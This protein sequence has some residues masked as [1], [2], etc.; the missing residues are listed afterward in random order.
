MAARWAR[1]LLEEGAE[2]IGIVVLDLHARRS[3]IERI[4]RHQIDPG[5]ALTPGDEG[6]VFSLSLGQPLAAQGPVHAALELL[7]LD[8]RPTLDQVSF[9][10]RSP[11]LAASQ[12]ESDRRAWFDRKLRS[13]RQQ[14]MSRRQLLRMA[15]E[16]APE[17]ASV[18]EKIDCG[19][20]S[21]CL[22]GE[23][24]WRFDRLLRE[25]G[26]PGERP[27]SSRE[28]QVIK[29]WREKLLPAMASLDTVSTPMT[30]A[31][32]LALLRRLAG[33]TEFQIEA[34]T[35]PVQVVGLLESAGLSFDHLCVVGMNEDAFPAPARPNPFIP[36][37]LQITKQMPHA[38]AARELSF[39]RRVLDRLLAASPDVVF[40]YAARRG[41]C[42]LRPSPLIGRFVEAEAPEATSHD[43]RGQMTAQGPDLAGIEDRDGPPLTDGRAEGG[44]GILKD[45]SLC[46]FRAYAHHRLKCRGLESP[47][48]GLDHQTRG[49][50][51]HKA[52]EYVWKE[53]Q[54]LECL[55]ALD[56]SDLDAIVARHVDVAIEDYFETRPTPPARL[57]ELER[58]RLCSLIGEW[59]GEVELK[60]PMFR[61]E[62]IEE[63]HLERIGPLEIRTV[64]DRIDRLE[65]GS[66]V[67]LDY[68]TGQQ[69]GAD[70]L[71]GERLLEPQLPIY[72]AGSSGQ[73]ADGVAFA[74]V[75]RGD[76]RMV[77]VA[78]SG[79][80]LPR[81]A[82]VS[83]SKQAQAL[84]IEDWNRL[85]AH[86]R[87]QL[88]ALAAGFAAGEAAV[89]PVSRE[90]ACRFCDLGGFCRIAERQCEEA[91][92]E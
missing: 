19:K 5:A 4:F 65:D 21:R 51:L 47:Q 38:S 91:S 74:R 60:R 35:G 18:L 34:E 58:R 20:S 2:S 82:G 72:A 28:Y 26:W 53:L 70:K 57:L 41:D 22:P 71:I 62:Q 63:D 50:L 24:A 10:L 12:S 69:V 56:E 68:K 83:E 90:D 30:G 42:E 44:T 77:G 32:A 15:G 8:H 37:P 79:D 3:I 29:A 49:S 86:W 25:A 75:R 7:R 17:F 87:D 27:L 85:I 88:E 1:R 9:L 81:V 6:G 48:A 84:D 52:L 13:G 33:E 14:S 46:P 43:P 31:A 11:Y 61:V 23:W 78:R 36:L 59:L 66:R 92:D 16:A 55:A 73:E 76:C 67:I 40:S 45:Q 64:V 54:S 39:A 80:L 89:D